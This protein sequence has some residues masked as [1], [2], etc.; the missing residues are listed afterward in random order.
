[1]SCQLEND[2]QNWQNH[3]KKQKHHAALSARLVRQ[4]PSKRTAQEMG[5]PGLFPRSGTVPRVSLQPVVHRSGQSLTLTY[6]GSDVSVSH[7]RPRAFR[8]L[9]ILAHFQN[10]ISRDFT[11]RIQVKELTVVFPVFGNSPG[12]LECI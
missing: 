7:V 8:H 11:D 4:D 1:M 12:A 3:A 5:D 6:S 10:L 9:T 2:R